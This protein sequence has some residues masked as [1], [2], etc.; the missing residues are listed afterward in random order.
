MFRK[1]TW[2][3]V[4]ALA[5]VI[6]VLVV[7]R[8]DKAKQRTQT[9]NSVTAPVT[10][11]SRQWVAITAAS[12]QQAP[13]ECARL[14]DGGFTCGACRDDSSCPPGQACVVSLTSGRTECQ[15]SECAKNE[16]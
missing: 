14:A 12:E 11:S 9:E 8:K 4:V 10:R 15:G 6:V 2:G 3:L 13:S 16:E 1:L 7:S 5:A